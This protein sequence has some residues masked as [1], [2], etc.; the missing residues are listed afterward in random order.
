MPPAINRWWISEDF[1]MHGRSPGDGQQIRYCGNSPWA[2]FASSGIGADED[3]MAD[4]LLFGAIEP[5]PNCR[6]NWKNSRSSVVTP[7]LCSS[8]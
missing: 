8:A 1:E 4:Q 2:G 3:T 5:A 7:W 6:P